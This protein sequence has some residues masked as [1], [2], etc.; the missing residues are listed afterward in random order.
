[1][2]TR[3]TQFRVSASLRVASGQD[4]LKER[5]RILLD[6]I[7]EC[8]RDAFWILWQIHAE[9]LFGVGLR[10][11]RG[12]ADEAHDILGD[13]SVR[14]IEDMPRHALFIRDSRRWLTRSVVNIAI[15]RFRTYRQHVVAVGTFE[16]LALAATADSLVQARTPEDDASSSQL[17]RRTI[18]QIAALPERLRV[19]AALH[20]LLYRSYD[21]IADELGI[22]A[23]LARKRIQEARDILKQKRFEREN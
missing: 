13:A 2:L 21:E 7:A 19:T 22:S 8:D 5:E 6:R 18:V 12:N 20:F 11:C 16:G 17:L 9:Y 3:V 23:A 1:M 14:L 4:D 10:L 15:D